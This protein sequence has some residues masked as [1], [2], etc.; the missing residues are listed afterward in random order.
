[1]EVDVVTAWLYKY[2]WFPS[3]PVIWKQ[4]THRL[5]KELTAETFV[6][7]TSLHQALS[8]QNP[9]GVWDALGDTPLTDR[10]VDMLDRLMRIRIKNDHSRASL[11]VYDLVDLEEVISE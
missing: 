5:V 9:D 10:C 3:L 4:V 7:L 1:M 11:R 6:G 8:T 2:E